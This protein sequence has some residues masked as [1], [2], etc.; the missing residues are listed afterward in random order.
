MDQN[1]QKNTAPR[2]GSG[3]IVGALIAAAVIVVI[4]LVLAGACVRTVPT[5]YTGI[6]TTF[7]KVE[8]S[9]LDA[10]VHIKAP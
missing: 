7:G 5:G 4:V 9:N 2:K 6:L 3:K 1:V 10:G 8:D